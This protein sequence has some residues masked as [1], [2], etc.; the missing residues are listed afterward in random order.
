MGAVSAWAV[1]LAEEEPRA[2]DE[3][4]H[5]CDGVT[6]EGGDRAI[7]FICFRTP[8]ALCFTPQHSA[9]AQRESIENSI[10]FTSTWLSIFLKLR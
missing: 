4:V 1:G 10:S 7:I 5:E 8:A 9:E 3:G 2:H 6:R